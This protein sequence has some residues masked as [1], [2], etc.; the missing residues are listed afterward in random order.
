MR[1]GKP[2]IMRTAA[3]SSAALPTRATRIAV[4]ITENLLW[5]GA[6]LNNEALY[7]RNTQAPV[8]SS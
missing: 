7:L 1:A 4:D 5:R 2:A 8:N 6:G 3:A